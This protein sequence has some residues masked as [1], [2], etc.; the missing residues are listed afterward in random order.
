MTLLDEVRLLP[1][2]AE[3][4]AAARAELPQKDNLCGAFT[5][6]V[7]LRAHGVAV[8]GQ[9]EVALAAGTVLPT[10]AVPSLPPGEAGRSDYRAPLPVTG[11]PARAGTSAIGVARAVERLAGAS[12]AVVPACGEWT[13]QAVLRLLAGAYRL[14][15]VAV[16]G[17]VDTGAFAAHD[18][19]TRALRDYLDTGIPPLW[20]SRWRVGHF[21]L[22]V[23]VLSGSEGTLVSIAD[24]YPSLGRRG[25]HLQPAG[26]VAAALRREG[27]APGGLLLVVPAAEAPAA[28][29][30]VE[31]A[32]LHPRLWDNG[33]P[34]PAD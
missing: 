10:A 16:I 32:G 33:S 4:L 8:P 12:L 31:R 24:T 2:A 11:D 34:A 21:V 26:H 14:S 15:R 9:D 13:E 7:A 17:N 6:L 1:G 20:M 28:R 23:G 3:V 30:V 22:V 5:G 19:P 18:T 27:M 29:D 25:V